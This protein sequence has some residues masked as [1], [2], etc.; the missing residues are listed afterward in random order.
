M[1]LV[2]YAL[3]RE[4]GDLRK[5]IADRSALAEGLRGFK[6]RIGG[7]DIALIATGIGV[8]QARRAARL[9]LQMIPQPRMVISTGVA[10]GLAPELQA[11]DLV[12]ADRMLLESSGDGV[13]TEVTRIAPEMMRFARAALRRAGLNAASGA[14]LTARRVMASAAAKHDAYLRSSAT[15]VDMES[16]AIAEELAS[17]CWPF[18]CVRAVIDGVDDE[19]PGADLPDEFGHVA[20]LKAVAYFVKNPSALA[21]VPATLKNF[22]RATV[23]I[24]AAMEA[25]CAGNDG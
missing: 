22:R 20:P 18:V 7:E 15:A 6:G 17:A 4:V 13:V 12:I 9:A 14:L 19:V 24:A 11:G 8:E 21:Q 25:L 3:R 2:F 1:I 5:R 23:A 10:G 16:A